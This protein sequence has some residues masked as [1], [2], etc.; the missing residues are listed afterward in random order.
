MC[1]APDGS[2]RGWGMS[3]WGRSPVAAL[4]Y[5][6]RNGDRR[7]PLRSEAPKSRHRLLFS[8]N[9]KDIAQI[10]AVGA[11]GE[12]D[13][14]GEHELAGF[15]AVSLRHGGDGFLGFFRRPIGSIRELISEGGEQGG[16]R[17]GFRFSDGFRILGALSVRRKSTACRDFMLPKHLVKVGEDFRFE[18]HACVMLSRPSFGSSGSDHSCGARIFR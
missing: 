10:R 1:V 3:E 2:G 7:S 13:S 6:T 18:A 12:G 9:D 5:G 15:R 8:K 17:I 16:V 4:S 14:H 11:T